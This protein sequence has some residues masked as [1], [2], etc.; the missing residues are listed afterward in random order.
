MPRKI[1]I[2][3][4][5]AYDKRSGDV[6]HCPYTMPFCGPICCAWMVE[7]R[8]NGAG[9]GE[10]QQAV[11]GAMGT[12]GWCIGQIVSESNGTSTP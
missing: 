4:G 12:N 1:E 11:C 8:W 7:T 5:A 2:I 3:D 6:M 10:Y 9:D